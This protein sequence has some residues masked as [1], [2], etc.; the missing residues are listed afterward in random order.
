MTSF[1]ESPLFQKMD[2]WHYLI[3][4]PHQQQFVSGVNIGCQWDFFSLF[5]FANYSRSFLRP[6]CDPDVHSSG[7][8]SLSICLGKQ[9]AAWVKHL[10][11]PSLKGLPFWCKWLECFYSPLITAPLLMT[12]QSVL[13]R[14]DSADA[15]P[16]IFL[17]SHSFRD[18]GV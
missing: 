13:I 10:I 17:Q 12:T 7:G 18:M 16:S 8:R 9:T 11:K 4:N 6:E 5:M 2:C 1:R 15:T 14:T 3:P